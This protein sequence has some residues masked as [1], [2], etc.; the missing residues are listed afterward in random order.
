MNQLYGIRGYGEWRVL[1]NVW[2]RWDMARAM[3]RVIGQLYWA[4]TPAE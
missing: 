4:D 2:A 1:L 3:S